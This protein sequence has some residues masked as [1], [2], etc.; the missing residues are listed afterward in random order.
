[1]RG[2]YALVREVTAV[3]EGSADIEPLTLTDPSSSSFSASPPLSARCTNMR[4]T[5]AVTKSVIVVEC[6][7]K[8]LQVVLRL[9]FI[10]GSLEKD[11]P[12]H[13]NRQGHAL[14]SSLSPH[15]PGH[16]RQRPAEESQCQESAI[17]ISL[18]GFEPLTRASVLQSV[19][20]AQNQPTAVS[21][22]FELSC[23][24]IGVKCEKG[25]SRKRPPQSFF[26]ASSLHQQHLVTLSSP[27]FLACP[28][29]HCQTI[30][31]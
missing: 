19:K 17:G 16:R 8:S 5:K 28:E 21:C 15:R 7:H 20:L 12:L 1:M 25:R 3:C 9:T 23:S 18:L 22:V 26:A 4:I 11:F 6:E 24:G 31:G 30:H 13:H 27:S 29:L 10:Q 14:L 2:S